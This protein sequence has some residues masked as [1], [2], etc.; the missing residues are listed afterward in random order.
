MRK[1]LRA[2]LLNLLKPVGLIIALNTGLFFAVDPAFAR[3]Q[4]CLLFCPLQLS[5]T[6]VFDPTGTCTCKCRA[7]DPGE[8]GH[9]AGILRGRP[10]VETVILGT[11]SDGENVTYVPARRGEKNSKKSA[12]GRLRELL[13]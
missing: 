3:P 1:H 4:V 6:L 7:F 11:A 12:R 10:A 2:K 5:C 8:L 9:D 13:K